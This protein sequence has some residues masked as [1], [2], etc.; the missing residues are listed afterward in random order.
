MRKLERIEKSRKMNTFTTKQV[1]E[2][3]CV[4][5]IGNIE[6]IL[7]SLTNK[8]LIYKQP[9]NRWRTTSLGRAIEHRLEDEYRIREYGYRIN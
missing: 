9:R 8:G 3:L 6:D 4:Y 5:Q 2:K 7:K 1:E